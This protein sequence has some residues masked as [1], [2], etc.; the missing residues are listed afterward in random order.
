MSNVINMFTEVNATQVTLNDAN[1]W[2]QVGPKITINT[3]LSPKVK[4]GGRIQDIAVAAFTTRTTRLTALFVTQCREAT[5]TVGEQIIGQ[6]AAFSTFPKSTSASGSS[7]SFNEGHTH[8]VSQH[9]HNM[10]HSH[11]INIVTQRSIS[12]PFEVR[13]TIDDEPMSPPAAIFPGS[14]QDSINQSLLAIKDVKDGKHTITVW[15]RS[16]G[17]PG[18]VLG[19]RT[20]TIWETEIENT[21]EQVFTQ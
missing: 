1:S 8:S 5:Q 3:K 18:A 10:D 21:K 9:S 16:R 14:I 11:N 17:I 7:T 15:C 4:K 20:L 12:I 13:I 6:T 19:N 2:V